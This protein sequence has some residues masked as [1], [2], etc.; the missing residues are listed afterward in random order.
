M[1]ND[2]GYPLEVAADLSIDSFVNSLRRFLSRRGQVKKIISDQGTN[3]IGARS[4]LQ[5]F[6]VIVS[7]SVVNN[8][9]LIRGI[10]W[11]KNPPGASHFGG[12]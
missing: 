7:S 5:L 8:Q 6:G 4:C 12:V 11:D 1:L 3:F 2:E 9:L 10:E